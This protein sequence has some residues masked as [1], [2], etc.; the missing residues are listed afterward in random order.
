[1]GLGVLRERL[2]EITLVVLGLLALKAALIFARCS[3]FRLPTDDALRAGYLLAQ[4]PY[5]GRQGYRYGD[6]R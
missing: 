5:T 4:G 1:M 6:F 2:L 3:G